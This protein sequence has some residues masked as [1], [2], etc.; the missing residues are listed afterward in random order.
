MHV[1]F[2]RDFDWHPPEKHRQVTIV[3]K[4]GKTY[5]VR[6]AC[7]RDAIAAGAAEPLKQEKYHGS[8]QC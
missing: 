8:Q 2:L 1:R 4:A 7:A 6:R 3:F 5:F